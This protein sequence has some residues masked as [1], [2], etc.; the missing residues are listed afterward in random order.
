[1]T[2]TRIIN[3]IQEIENSGWK[4]KE[5]DFKLEWWAD[6]VIKFQS[7]WSPKS[8]CFYLITKVDPYPFGSKFNSEK[9][10][11]I[12]WA[13]DVSN[14]FPI[15]ENSILKNWS[16]KELKPKTSEIIIFINSLRN[17]I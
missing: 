6:V 12:I 2:D 1:M 13:I 16:L 7:T 10:N 17:N 5:T 9:N 14:D 3:L 8:S 4:S 15:K 11:S